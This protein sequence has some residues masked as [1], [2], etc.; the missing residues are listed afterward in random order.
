MS[1]E[2]G[3]PEYWV[4]NLRDRHVEVRTMPAADGH[5]QLVT[6]RPGEP[7][8]LERFGDICVAVDDILPSLHAG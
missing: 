8:T 6:R 3:I 1:S 4:V 7:L 5:T 2:H